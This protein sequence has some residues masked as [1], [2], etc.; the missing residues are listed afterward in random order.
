MA[1]PNPTL[2]DVGPEDD[3]E[4]VRTADRLPSDWQIVSV[5]DKLNQKLTAGMTLPEMKADHTLANFIPG[6]LTLGISG[7]WE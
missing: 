4:A 2:E 3:S 6:E 5:Y 7:G 1:T